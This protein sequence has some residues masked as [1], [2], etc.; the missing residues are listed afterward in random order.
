[1]RMAQL[2]R[3]EVSSLPADTGIYEGVGKM[4]VSSPPSPFATPFPAIQHC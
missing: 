1:M 3:N 4:L 2:T